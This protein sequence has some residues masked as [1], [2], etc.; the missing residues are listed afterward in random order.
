[1]TQDVVLQTFP[2][3][4]RPEVTWV[5]ITPLSAYNDANTGFSTVMLTGESGSFPWELRGR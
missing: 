3:P 4:L 2:V 1:M 5:K